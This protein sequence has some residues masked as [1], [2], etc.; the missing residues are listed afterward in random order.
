MLKSRFVP[1]GVYDEIYLGLDSCGQEAARQ[2]FLRLVTL[3][4]GAEDTRR[5][6][7]RSELLALSDMVDGQQARIDSALSHSHSLTLT[8]LSLF[9]S[10]SSGRWCSRKATRPSTEEH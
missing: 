7:S 3:G 6:V 5:R 2:L 9:L 8:L 1:G 10:L 4:E